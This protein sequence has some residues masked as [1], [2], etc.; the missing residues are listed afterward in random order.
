MNGKKKKKKRLGSV[1]AAL[2]TL[3]ALSSEPQKLE[4][5]KLHSVTEGEFLEGF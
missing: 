3:F 1:S 5:E 4:M 2:F